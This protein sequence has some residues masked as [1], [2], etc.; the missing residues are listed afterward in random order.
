MAT[1]FVLDALEQ[2]I[3]DRC[4]DGVAGFVHYSDRGTQTCAGGAWGACTG[5]VMPMMEV[6]N[7]LDDDCDGAADDGILGLGTDCDGSDADLCSEGVFVCDPAGGGGTVCDDATGDAI[8]ACNTV[9][10][11]CDDAAVVVEEVGPQVV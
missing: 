6:C 10:D 5:E 8:E 7:G 9:D 4:G 1:D 2:A 3:Y 11:D